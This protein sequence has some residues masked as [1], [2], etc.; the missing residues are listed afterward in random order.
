MRGDIQFKHKYANHWKIMI[1]WGLK[2][3]TTLAFTI[4]VV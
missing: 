2:T 1:F 4:K 3:T